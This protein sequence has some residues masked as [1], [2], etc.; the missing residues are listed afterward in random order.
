[1]YL[2]RL[3]SGPDD[4]A[5]CERIERVL[6]LGWSLHGSPCITFTGDA[7]IVAQAITN[8][9]DG[10]YEGFKHLKVMHPPEEDPWVLPA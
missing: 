6:N 10:D 2:Y 9:V 5:F 1:M 8:E 4:A 7:A 3:L